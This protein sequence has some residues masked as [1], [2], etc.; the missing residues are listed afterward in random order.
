MQT[1]L[2]EITDYPNFCKKASSDEILFTNFKQ[3]PIYTEILEHVSPSL[4][5]EYYNVIKNYYPSSLSK[6]KE[7]S[8]NDNYG[9]PN[10]HFYEFGSYSPTTL[11]YLKVASELNYCFLN[12]KDFNILEI[13]GGYGGQALISDIIHGYKSWTIIDLPEVIELQKKYIS[14]FNNKK[15]NCISFMETYEDKKYDLIISNYA[16]SECS[17][18]IELDYIKKVMSNNEK[19]YLTLNFIQTNDDRFNNMLSLEEIKNKLNVNIYSEMPNT[20]PANCI[21]MRNNDNSPYPSNTIL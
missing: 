10:L 3:N 19:L 7:I 8:I 2:S 15:I 6:L 5:Q 21:A 20:A 4:G 11:R 14:N 13:G 17:R 18:E 9:N 16:F 12:I 1:S